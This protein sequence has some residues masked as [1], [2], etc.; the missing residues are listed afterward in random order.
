MIFYIILRFVMPFIQAASSRGTALEFSPKLSTISPLPDHLSC[1]V[2][3]AIPSLTIRPNVSLACR[4][5]VLQ[6][7]LG[8]RHRGRIDMMQN[9][10]I[11][12]NHFAIYRVPV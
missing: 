10:P 6:K 12:V 5:Y 4:V 7:A 8:I 1:E 2:T 3:V 11:C 9:L